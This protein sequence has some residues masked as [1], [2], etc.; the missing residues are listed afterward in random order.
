MSTSLSFLQQDS[1]TRPLQDIH[2]RQEQC[3]ATFHVEHSMLGCVKLQV[4]S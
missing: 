4:S 2:L 1:G 3:F